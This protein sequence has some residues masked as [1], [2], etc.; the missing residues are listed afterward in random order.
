[1]APL[2]QSD[3]ACTQI[4]IVQTKTNTSLIFIT[5]SNVHSYNIP[6]KFP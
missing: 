4:H 6:V 3:V 2:N 1:M 5:V